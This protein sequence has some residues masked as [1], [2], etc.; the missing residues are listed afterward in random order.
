MWVYGDVCTEIELKQKLGMRKSGFGV[1]WTPDI[2]DR[3]LKLM[4]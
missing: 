1:R 4:S 3:V 2:H